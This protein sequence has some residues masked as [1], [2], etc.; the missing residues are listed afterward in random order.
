MAVVNGGNELRRNLNI[1]LEE[2]RMNGAIEAL[3]LDFFGVNKG[4]VPDRMTANADSG[5]HAHS[6]AH[7]PTTA[8]PPVRAARTA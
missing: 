1:A 3:A 8:T 5:R 7:S 2:L 4:I 6:A